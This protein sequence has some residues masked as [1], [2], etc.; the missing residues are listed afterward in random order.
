MQTALQSSEQPKA[1]AAFEE[2]AKKLAAGQSAGKQF[3]SS[4]AQEEELF[5]KTTKKQAEK[6]LGASDGNVRPPAQT[7]CDLFMT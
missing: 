4:R 5:E 6:L 2:A 3:A 7:K 1:S